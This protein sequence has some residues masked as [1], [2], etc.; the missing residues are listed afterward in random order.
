MSDFVQQ[1]SGRSVRRPEITATEVKP[2]FPPG[3][4]PQ[5]GGPRPS[6]PPSGPAPTGA[7]GPTAELP[8]RL[9]EAEIDDPSSFDQGPTDDPS[10]NDHDPSLGGT[11]D[12]SSDAYAIE[13]MMAAH[14]YS[15][16][17]Y[18][19]SA[20]TLRPRRPGPRGPNV[21]FLLPAHL[22]RVRASKVSLLTDEVAAQA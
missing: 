2:L 14:G 4:S 17:V 12:P 15:P 3:S 16:W 6:T 11:D 8:D 22:E 18:D 19:V 13:A 9:D 20:R 10:S 7:P 1:L 5:T 21:F